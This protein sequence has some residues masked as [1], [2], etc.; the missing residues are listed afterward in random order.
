MILNGSV[1]YGHIMKKFKIK[2]LENK[3]Q[4]AFCLNK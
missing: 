1:V 3:I 2:H 4:G